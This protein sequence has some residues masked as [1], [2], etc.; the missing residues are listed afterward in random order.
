[1]R[2]NITK[3]VWALLISYLFWKLSRSD[4]AGS[5]DL[6]L[7]GF[8][9]FIAVVELGIFIVTRK[10][11]LGTKKE[12]INPYFVS[13]FDKIRWWFIRQRCKLFGHDISKGGAL[14]IRCDRCGKIAITALK[15]LFSE[16]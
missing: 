13:K 3:L 16:D 7:M 6:W 12:E 5:F 1:M 10:F 4:Q 11:K 15:E 14:P 8:W 2:D 9:I